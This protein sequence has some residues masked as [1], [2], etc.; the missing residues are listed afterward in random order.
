MT[1]CSTLTRQGRTGIYEIVFG[2]KQNIYT[3]N[4]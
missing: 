1:K 3:W 2:L 4:P